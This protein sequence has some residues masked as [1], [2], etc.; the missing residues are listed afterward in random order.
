MAETLGSFLRQKR[1][2]LGLTLDKAAGLTRIRAKHLQAIESDDL[3]SIPS[4]TQARG[5][6]RNYATFLGV[7]PE[8]IAAHTGGTRPRPA[9]APAAAASV[10]PAVP[11][12]EPRPTAASSTQPRAP[13]APPVI[14]RSAAYAKPAARPP[15][16]RKWF[17]LDMLLGGA[18][19]LVIVALIGW[20]GYH[21]VVGWK[22]GSTPTSTRPFIALDSTA[23]GTASPD[24]ETAAPVEAGTAASETAPLE[25]AASYSETGAAPGTVEIST[26]TATTLPTPLG[27]VYTDVRIHI[28]VIQRAYLMVKVDGREAF[29]GRVL[30]EETYDYV[31]QQSVT[32]STGNG[33]GIRVVFNGV[34]QGT[35]GRFGEVVSQTYAPTGLVE[36]TPEPSATATVTLTPTRT[37]KP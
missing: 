7:S 2:A 32:V 5:F 8:E 23:A 33:A 31:G 19:T 17:R 12:P 3:S 21:A 14:S 34:D 27:G 13:V 9:N 35:M 24:A 6:I 37:K 11:P 16:G 29:S 28:V 26:P 4:V 15:A 1:E 18:V 22:G 30:P 20:G 25:T 36:P 10:P